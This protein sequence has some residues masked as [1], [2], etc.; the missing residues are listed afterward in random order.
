MVSRSLA[1]QRRR[2]SSRTASSLVPLWAT[3]V[4][5]TGWRDSTQRLAMLW[6]KYTVPAPGEPGS[7][8]WKGTNNAWQ[9]GGGA[10]WVTGTYDPDTNQTFWGTGNPAPQYDSKYRPGD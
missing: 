3:S 1:S 9:T 7:E 10:V 8:T 4:C 6:R 5:V 2:S